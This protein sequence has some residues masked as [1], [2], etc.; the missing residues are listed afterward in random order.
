M[1]LAVLNGNINELGI[2]GLLG[3]CENEGRV[4][5]SVL[6][7]VFA[8]GCNLSVLYSGNR[9]RKSRRIFEMNWTC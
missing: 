6:G 4:C 3:G 2:F 8:D 9:Y 7:L 1:F 5:G